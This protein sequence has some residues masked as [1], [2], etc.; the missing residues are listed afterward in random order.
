VLKYAYILI[1]GAGLLACSSVRD[2]Y[3]E[4]ES[5]P[6]TAEYEKPNAIDSMIQ[7]YRTA[8]DAEMSEVIAKAKYDFERGRPNGV[9]NNWSTDALLMLYRSRFYRDEPVMCMLNV[10][11]LRNP[12]SKGDVLLS[13]MYKLMPFDNEV[14]FV[15]LPISVKKEIEDYLIMK[16]GEPIGGA[17]L[18][19][20]ELRINE[21]DDED[22]F[23][24]IT[25]DYL[26]GGGDK[27]Y[28]FK[29]NIEVNYANQLL[30]DA[31][32]EAAKKEGTLI[33]N[34]IERIFI[35]E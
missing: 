26:L 7:P 24:V 23:W 20:G 13:D 22:Y 34:D 2:I 19:G 15:K 6:V 4:P 14:V 18:K 35:D 16:N 27:M 21:F 28:F 1:I 10:G 31:F 12:I 33:Y 11:G 5:V 9:L 32:I 8:L 29:K 25:S 3:V 17:V 30:R